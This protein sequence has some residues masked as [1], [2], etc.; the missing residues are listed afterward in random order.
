MSLGILVPSSNKNKHNLGKSVLPDIL[1]APPKP[2]PPKQKLWSIEWLAKGW[3]LN[4]L[5]PK[6]Q[7][8]EILREAMQSDQKGGVLLQYHITTERQHIIQRLSSCSFRLIT[9]KLCKMH[10]HKLS[11]FKMVELYYSP[12]WNTYITENICEVI[13]LPNYL[14]F[15]VRLGCP[16]YAFQLDLMI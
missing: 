10:Y 16:W 12:N 13:P 14:F 5:Q 4:L 11:W 1:N 9:L 6:Q 8:L 2:Q 7:S 3:R 15:L